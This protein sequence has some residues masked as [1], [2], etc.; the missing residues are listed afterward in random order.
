MA[1][2]YEQ[3]LERVELWDSEIAPVSIFLSV[4]ITFLNYHVMGFPERK[5]LSSHIP[6]SKEGYWFYCHIFNKEELVMVS[7]V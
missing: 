5:H 2:E 1:S 7:E 4:S 6:P 3:N